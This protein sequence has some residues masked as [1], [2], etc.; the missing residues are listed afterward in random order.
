MCK[1]ECFIC[2]WHD[3]EWNEI[4]TLEDL[5]QAS[6]ENIYTLED[7]SD[8]RKSTNITRFNYCPICGEII[9]WKKIH[10]ISKCK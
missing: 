9:D 8:K 1:D 4:F 5:V 2:L 6:K 7:Y 3:S 10:K